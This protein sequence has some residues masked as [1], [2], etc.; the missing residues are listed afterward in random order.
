MLSQNNNKKHKHEPENSGGVFK[1]VLNFTIKASN[2]DKTFVVY[3]DGEIANGML[4]GKGEVWLFCPD[5]SDN[6][7]YYWEGEFTDG[8]P[9][10]N[11]CSSTNFPY[12]DNLLADLNSCLHA[13][14]NNREKSLFTTGFNHRNEFIIPLLGRRT[15]I[16]QEEPVLA[17]AFERFRS[18]AIDFLYIQ[19]SNEAPT[20]PPS[21]PAQVETPERPTSYAKPRCR[22]SSAAST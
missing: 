13:N 17:P 16:K 21:F 5:N 9:V 8:Q 20:T 7:I 1:G 15:R 22:L 11:R 19:D 10:S 18:Q 3:Y 12:G 14:T 6:N 2:L 4:D